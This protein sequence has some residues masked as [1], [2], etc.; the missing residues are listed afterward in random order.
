M[1]WAGVDFS[2]RESRLLLTAGRGE[3]GIVLTPWRMERGRT[4]PE[5]L[6]RDFMSVKQR[7]A[8]GRSDT[9]MW[10]WK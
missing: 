10:Q 8:M 2:R 4:P 5:A 1:R 9:D 3:G 7:G 6:N